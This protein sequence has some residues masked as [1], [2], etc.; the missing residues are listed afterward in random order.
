MV[1]INIRNIDQLLH[2]ASGQR[3]PVYN[4]HYFGVSRVVVVHRLDC[5]G[6]FKLGKII[7]PTLD[8]RRVDRRCSGDRAWWRWSKIRHLR[9]REPEVE[10]SHLG[11]S[12]TCLVWKNKSFRKMEGYINDVTLL[13]ALKFSCNNSLKF[14]ESSKL[15]FYCTLRCPENEI[16]KDRCHTMNFTQIYQSITWARQN[17]KIAKHGC[18]K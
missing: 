16:L 14:E 12:N 8:L 9:R 6:N 7:L 17:L 2:M 4:G 11:L 5:N 1:S 13:E 18:R 10:L 3:P 15:G